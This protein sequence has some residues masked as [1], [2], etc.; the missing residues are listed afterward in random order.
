[1]RCSAE[2]PEPAHPP[3]RA[4]MAITGGEQPTGLPVEA[5]GAFTK[6]TGLQI[7]FLSPTRVEGYVDVGPAQH[8]P[9]GIVHGGVWASVVETVGSVGGAAAAAD[10]GLLVVGV[11]NSTEFLRPMRTG[12]ASVVAVP[13][14]QGRTQQLWD[15]RIEDTDGRLVAIGRLRLQNLDRPAERT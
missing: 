12:R 1:M 4:R 2:M 3:E 11:H 10:R 13:L 14:H 8:Q 7:T 9:N 6:T 5:L 15:V